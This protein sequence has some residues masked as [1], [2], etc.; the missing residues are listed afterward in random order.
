[1]TLFCLILPIN[2]HC[3]HKTCNRLTFVADIQCDCYEAEIDFRFIT[4]CIEVSKCLSFQALC[5]AMYVSMGLSHSSA[6]WCKVRNLHM[7]TAGSVATSKATLWEPQLG[8]T[9]W[10]CELL[11]RPQPW[12]GQNAN[13]GMQSDENSCTGNTLLPAYTSRSKLC[14]STVINELLVFLRNCVACLKITLFSGG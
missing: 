11:V 5:I 10:L 13:Q 12:S 1:M 9:F 3:L 4:R 14:R 7:R 6:E 8:S 2:R